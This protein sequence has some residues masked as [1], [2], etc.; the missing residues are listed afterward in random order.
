MTYAVVTYNQASGLPEELTGPFLFREDALEVRDS[1][2]AITGS[3]GRG[4][5]HY[6]VEF[7]V[8]EDQ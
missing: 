2:R 6:V 1:L 7:E 5:R 3:V 8:E 4:E